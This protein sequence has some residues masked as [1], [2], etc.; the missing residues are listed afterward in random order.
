MAALFSEQNPGGNS[1]AAGKNT[2]ADFPPG[3]KNNSKDAKTIYGIN[4]NKVCILI[5]NKIRLWYYNI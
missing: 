4:L 5:V 3:E 2:G 1:T